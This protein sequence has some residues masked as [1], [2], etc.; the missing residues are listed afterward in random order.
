LPSLPLSV[1]RESKTHRRRSRPQSP[2]NERGRLHSKAPYEPLG[3][4]ILAGS[5]GALLPAIAFEGV[6]YLGYGRTEQTESYRL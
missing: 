6:H 3:R 4:G 2:E 5:P 1:L